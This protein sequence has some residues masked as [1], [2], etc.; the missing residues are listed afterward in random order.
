MA[1]ANSKRPP[2]HPDSAEP[3]VDDMDDEDEEWGVNATKPTGEPQL[4]D[5]ILPTLPDSGIQELI[6]KDEDDEEF[7]LT[8]EETRTANFLQEPAY[9]IRMFFSSYY[10]DRGLIWDPHKCQQLHLTQ[11]TPPLKPY[12]PRVEGG[13]QGVRGGGFRVACDTNDGGGAGGSEDIGGVVESVGQE[14]AD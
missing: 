7:E 5:G 12:E 1:S 3:P 13:A 11:P 4:D 2:H 14:V 9:H 8:A 10:I 6:A